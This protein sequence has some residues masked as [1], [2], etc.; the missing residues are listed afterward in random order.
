MEKSRSL[1]PWKI[2]SASAILIWAL[3]MGM[4]VKKTYFSSLSH[5]VGLRVAG[6]T[7]I[8]AGES[9]MGIYLQDRKVGYSVSRWEKED[10]DWH[11][12]ERTV[13]ELMVMGQP[14]SVQISTHCLLDPSLLMKSFRFHLSAGEVEFLAEGETRGKGR[15]LV[16]RLSGIG[17]KGKREMVI[18]VREVPLLSPNL[19]FLLKNRT[20][21][22]GQRFTFPFFDPATLQVEELRMEVEGRERLRTGKEQVEA[23]K[24]RQSFK[25]LTISTWVSQEGEVLREESPLGFTL[26]K[27]EKETAILKGRG[28]GK[29]EDLIA[30][31]AVDSPVPIPDPQSIRILR[32]HLGDLAREG[33]DLEGGRQRVRG[34]ILEIRREVLDFPPSKLPI[35]EP[36]LAAYLQATPFIQ[37]DHPE[38]KR[39]AGSILQGERDSLTA[40]KMLAAWV[41]E[42]IE[43]R[44]TLSIPSALEV[45]QSRV[46]D[47]NEHTILYVGLARSVGLPAKVA[48]GLVYVK[49]KFY[50]HAWPEVFVGRWVAIDPTLNQFPADAT[51][52]RLIEGGLERQA[53]LVRLMGKVSLQILG[54]Q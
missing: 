13:M 3:L 15:E 33:L 32:I 4:L 22:E 7:G 10:L 14:Q 35:R 24:V 31:A 47:C 5:P 19:R 28:G 49:G 39:M 52:L 1:S 23:F 41:F 30:L 12:T 45:L 17:E 42:R 26:V 48:S 53:E 37:S 6:Q 11:M 2:A 8:Q 20:L 21:K 25:G 43:K 9:W 36:S 16:V 18:P 50:Y 29:A 27:E 38:L 51:H 44:P 46:G 34:E 40:A 54:F